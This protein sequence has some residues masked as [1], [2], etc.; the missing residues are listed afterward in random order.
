[1]REIL[2]SI[3]ILFV[4][5]LNVTAQLDSSLEYIESTDGYLYEGWYLDHD[6][7]NVWFHSVAGDTIVF[8]KSEI[9]QYI[10]PKD[11]FIYPNQ[12][13]HRKNGKFSSLGFL[14][15]GEGAGSFTLQFSYAHG[16]RITPRTLVGGGLAF[17]FTGHQEYFDD[18]VFF[19]ELFLY[20]KHYI[21]N[22]RIRPFIDVKAGGF[23]GIETTTI[24][25]F[26]PGP[27]IQGS[28]GLEF[29]RPTETRF[30][31]KFSYLGLYALSKTNENDD[32]AIN[33]SLLGL[34]FNF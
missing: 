28:I 3:F 14:V 15:S 22:K 8:S 4:F 33:R 9:I 19:G 26:T 11:Y 34:V 20:V 1:M 23:S 7:T 29:A 24:N 13:Y 16:K 2:L 18:Q 12:K 27:I 21:N 6:E 5:S 17:N 32:L 31:I 10:Y 25:D 30:S